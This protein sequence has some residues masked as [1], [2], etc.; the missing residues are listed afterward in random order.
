MQTAMGSFV[1]E[2]TALYS[3]LLSHQSFFPKPLMFQRQPVIFM[4]MKT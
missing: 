2:T 4:Q 3:P 1:I